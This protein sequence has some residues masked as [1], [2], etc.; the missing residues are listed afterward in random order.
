MF[1]AGVGSSPT[2]SQLSTHLKENWF[3]DNLLSGLLG[4]AI[5]ALYPLLVTKGMVLM[6]T[7]VI[8]LP[9]TA[10]GELV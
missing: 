10:C 6:S 4:A 9:L 7:L 1:A 3:A 2:L 8:L 5:S